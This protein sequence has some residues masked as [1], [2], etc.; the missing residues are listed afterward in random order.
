MRTLRS[1]L[2]LGN[3]ILPNHCKTLSKLQIYKVESKL[4]SELLHPPGPA[5]R[6]PAAQSQRSS[7]RCNAATLKPAL[8]AKAAAWSPANAES[9]EEEDDEASFQVGA[10]VR[11]AHST[12]HPLHN[13]TT[14]G[15]GAD[16][17]VVDVR[18]GGWRTVLCADGQE[19]KRRRSSLCP[20]PDAPPAA[21]HERATIAAEPKAPAEQYGNEKYIT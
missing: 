1:K 16:G 19:L 13:L 18:R 12:K 4:K 21:P 9:S 7:K 11:D 3:N 17:V 6:A 20:A 10:W 8:V 15:S 2:L 5:P 14:G